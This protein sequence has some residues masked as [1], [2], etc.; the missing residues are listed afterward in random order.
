[1]LFSRN[2]IRHRQ[3][4]LQF[5]SQTYF[6]DLG[7]VEPNE[8]DI[9]ICIKDGVYQRSKFIKSREQSKA[10]VKA[11]T[12]NT[13][14]D[15]DS[16][17]KLCIYSYSDQLAQKQ[18]TVAIPILT[19]LGTYLLAKDTYDNYNEVEDEDGILEHDPGALRTKKILKW[20]MTGFTSIGWILMAN[21]LGERKHHICQIDLL[22]H[23]TVPN[24]SNE[25]LL[26]QWNGETRKIFIRNIQNT[27]NDEVQLGVTLDG[28]T[29]RIMKV[30]N[31]PEEPLMVTDLVFA[32]LTANTQS[33]LMDKWT[34]EDAKTM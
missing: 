14:L 24:Y 29:Y 32:V 33:V 21:R 10:K 30:H 18:L 20:F 19:F 5:A 2:L 3:R 15:F 8:T 7:I 25:L 6:Q 28:E 9:L 22:K 34:K 27:A 13:N 1:M 4:I 17:G 31:L 16:D 26:T 12:E 11:I 23:E